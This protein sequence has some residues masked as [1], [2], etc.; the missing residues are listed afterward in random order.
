MRRRY[1]NICKYLIWFEYIKL[2]GNKGIKADKLNELID[3]SVFI[4]SKFSF[5]RLSLSLML[6][7]VLSFL[8][9]I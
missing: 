8:L 3:A 4:D 5:S 1:V 6:V 7:I 2:R 9:P